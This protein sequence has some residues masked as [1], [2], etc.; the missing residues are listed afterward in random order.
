MCK[1]DHILFTSWL[2]PNSF[3]DYFILPKQE[4]VDYIKNDKLDYL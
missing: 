2:S 1:T 4:P 3:G